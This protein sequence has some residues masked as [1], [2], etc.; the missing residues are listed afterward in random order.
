[1]TNA[2]DVALEE[3]ISAADLLYAPGYDRFS[4][5]TTDELITEA[6]DTAKQADVAVIFAGLPEKMESEGYDR[7]HMKMPQGHCRL[8]EESS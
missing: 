3:G 4:G 8:I 2:Y 7:S 6:V 5:D 1:M